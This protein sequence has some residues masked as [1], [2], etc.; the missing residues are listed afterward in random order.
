MARTSS[1]DQKV[2]EKL[3]NRLQAA[4]THV[5]QALADTDPSHVLVE[6]TKELL[7]VHTEIRNLLLNSME[8]TGD[9]SSEEPEKIN[10]EAIKL[11]QE[12]HTAMASFTDV[13]K[14]LFMWRDHPETRIKDDSETGL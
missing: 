2:C 11:E 1:I 10:R 6:P 3:K 4:E 8:N 5:D 7:A 12:E 14:A 13:A 9:L